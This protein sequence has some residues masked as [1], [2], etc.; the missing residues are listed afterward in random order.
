MRTTPGFI[1]GQH[2]D[3]HETHFACYLR[4]M[5]TTA[6]SISVPL[7]AMEREPRMSQASYEA[8]LTA[9]RERISGEEAPVVTDEPAPMDPPTPPEPTIE[10]G[11]PKPSR[12]RG[13]TP[14]KEITKPG[15]DT[16]VSPEW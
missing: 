4:N 10:P 6:I 7:G 8:L 3:K 5:T 14:P 2:R 16:G 13:K 11:S 1:L 12:A 15:I 9:N